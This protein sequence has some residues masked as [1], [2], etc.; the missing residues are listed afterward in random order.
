MIICSKFYHPPNFFMLIGLINNSVYF[1]D[2][3]Q[4]ISLIF[5]QHKFVA[6]KNLDSRKVITPFL[7]FNFE[8]PVFRFFGLIVPHGPF[9]GVEGVQYSHF[10]LGQRKVENVDVCL[11]TRL[12]NRFWDW[13]YSTF[14]L[15]IEISRFIE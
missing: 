5:L 1:G 6:N 7:E 9:A 3:L 14:N 2:I 11:N 8:W 4:I 13:H 15:S 10:F 12:G